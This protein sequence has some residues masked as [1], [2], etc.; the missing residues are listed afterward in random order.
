MGICISASPVTK[1][2]FG[3]VAMSTGKRE[4]NKNNKE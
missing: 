4:K 3:H 2:A 1:I